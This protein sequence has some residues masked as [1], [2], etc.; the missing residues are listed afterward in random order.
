LRAETFTFSPGALIGGEFRFDIGTAG[1]ITLLLQALL[2]VLLANGR[3]AR[4]VVTGG[5]DVRQAPPVDYLAAVMLRHLACMGARVTLTVA[6][7][8]Y[9]PRGGAEV[10]V[11]IEPHA[12]RP[13]TLSM[14]GPLRRVEGVSHVANLPAHIAER[15]RGAAI[16]QLPALVADRTRIAVRVMGYPEAIGRGGA[17]V[18]WAETEHTVLGAARAAEIGVSAET[19]GTAVG[20]ELRADIESG[21]TVDVHAADQLLVYLALAGPGSSIMTRELTKHA[22]T[23]IWLIGQ[24]LTVRFVT[25]REGRLYRIATLA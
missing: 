21:A 10:T 17:I 15:M 1:S 3:H 23:A 2:P 22:Q 8:G 14:P 20:Q 9:Y 25:G 24:F 13:V 19:L 5:T 7:R 6:R 11:E 16:A 12:L 4:V 18:V